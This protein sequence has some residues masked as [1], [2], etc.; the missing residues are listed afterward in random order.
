MRDPKRIPKVLDAVRRLWRRKPEQSATHDYTVRCWGHD[1][2]FTPI[3]G[4]MRGHVI[5]WGDGLR[6]GDYLILPNRAATT[7][8]RIEAVEYYVDP[9]DMWSADVVFAPRGTTR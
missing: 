2:A 7:R 5:G 1:F 6:V 3:D 9:N 8:Y 4:G